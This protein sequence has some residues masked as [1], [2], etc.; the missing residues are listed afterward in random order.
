MEEDEAEEVPEIPGLRN[1]FVFSGEI[2]VEPNFDYRVG[3]LSIP[4]S[5][6]TVSI[7]AVCC[8]ENQVLVCLPDAAWH[9]LKKNRILPATSLKSAVR[10]LVRVGDTLDRSRAVPGEAALH[11][12]LGLL[13]GSL[14]GLVTY[15]EEEYAEK[16]F[17]LSDNG[18]PELPFAEALAAVCRDHFAFFTGESAPAGQDRG[19][20]V[21]GRLGRLEESMAELK[22]MM[23][24]LAAVKHP[25]PGVQGEHGAAAALSRFSG[26]DPNLARQALATGIQPEAI[27]EMG[28]LLA[29]PGLG[30]VPPQRGARLEKEEE[31]DEEDEE[32]LD[33]A[34]ELGS[35]GQL[36]RAVVSL[37]KIVKEMRGEKKA[38]K[39]RSLEA[40]LDR[41]EG[42]GSLREVGGSSRSKASALR[43]L[44]SALIHQPSLIYQSLEK[45]LQADWELSGSAAGVQVSQI[46]ARGWLEHRSRIQGYPSS[47]R[48]AWILAGVWDALRGNR[49]EEA[50]ARAAL[51]VAMMDQ[52]SCDRGQ[53]LL[54]AE[55]SLESP[56]PYSSFNMHSPPENWELQHS[57][58]LDPRWV[59][60]FLAKLRDMA[61]YQ[62]KRAKL[63]GRGAGGGGDQQ[64]QQPKKEAAG[65]GKGK[66]KKGKKEKAEEK[67]SQPAAAE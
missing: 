48:P 61:E 8:T 28:K 44:Q 40:I 54:A 35:G 34:D 24:N 18:M 13:H 5:T 26:L 31:S 41:A 38:A 4:D 49:I 52:Q 22:D 37:S 11:V 65:P 51:G 19:D 66:G 25:K 15:D 47:I 1:N 3:I 7:I 39:D 53:W 55:A 36:S 9:R 62:E 32:D 23:K 20:P 43:S 21:S 45:N 46:S 30:Q 56:P 6:V 60:L 12:W 33:G 64:Q 27:G 63:G 58:L 59:E 16:G 50:R 29:P 67:P 2:G 17:P 14:E 57:R 42:G 10:V